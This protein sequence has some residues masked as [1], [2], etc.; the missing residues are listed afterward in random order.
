MATAMAMPAPHTPQIALTRKMIAVAMHALPSSPGLPVFS[1]K[2]SALLRI[3]YT[4]A[5]RHWWQNSHT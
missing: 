2:K 4:P 3:Y 1:A 5:W